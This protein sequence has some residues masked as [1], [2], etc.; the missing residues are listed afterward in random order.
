MLGKLLS[1]APRVQVHICS[2]EGIV[3]ASLLLGCANESDKK[4]DASQARVALVCGSISLV[5][6][7]FVKFEKHRQTVQL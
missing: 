3:A 7:D 4:C 2:L 5:L 1:N 6:E